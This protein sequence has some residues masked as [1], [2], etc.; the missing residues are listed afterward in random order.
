MQ[1][2]IQ[3]SPPAHNDLFDITREE[4]TIVSK[5]GVQS[6]LVNVYAQ[7]AKVGIMI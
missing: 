3:I 6:G 5:S 1:Q 2:I 7:A 4:E